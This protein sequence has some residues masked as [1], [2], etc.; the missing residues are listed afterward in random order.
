M[1]IEKLKTKKGLRITFDTPFSLKADGTNFS[2]QQNSIFFSFN[3]AILNSTTLEIYFSSDPLLP[4]EEQPVFD[5]LNSFRLVISTQNYNLV[6]DFVYNELPEVGT[7]LIIDGSLNNNIE[8]DF[9]FEILKNE[10]EAFVVYLDFID[11]GTLKDSY[12]DVVIKEYKLHLFDDFPDKIYKL[13]KVV[14]DV[15]DLEFTF[16]KNFVYKIEVC[17]N[18][19]ADV[20]YKKLKKTKT[21]LPIMPT[22]YFSS[23]YQIKNLLEELELEINLFNGVE[24]QLQIWKFSEMAFAK[25]GFLKSS[26][27]TL[28]ESDFMILANYVSYKIIL[29]K[30]MASF[31][32]LTLEQSDKESNQG[33]K[34]LKLGEFEV[35]GIASPQETISSLNTFLRNIE[36]EIKE[37][38]FRRS[39]A[40]VDKNITVETRNSLLYPNKKSLVQ[41]V[42]KKGNKY[43]GTWW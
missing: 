38:S 22:N 36:N 32:S 34:G 2:V 35:K 8:L 11:D 20:E 33:Q 29:Q 10:N 37:I 9:D 42:N 41:V 39:F 24:S 15:V 21:V 30:Y 23:T 43:F 40:V 3:Q 16:K 26:I 31:L 5:E 28:T 12:F 14:S 17:F 6:N 1:L 27:E 19:D 13:K 18:P 4:P 7:G 25:A